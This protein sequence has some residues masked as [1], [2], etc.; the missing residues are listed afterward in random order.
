MIRHALLVAALALL[1]GLTATA[2]ANDFQYGP[3]GGPST[4][5]YYHWHQGHWHTYPSYY[6]PDWNG[7]PRLQ[8]GLRQWHPGQWH[9]H[10]GYS[11]WGYG[12]WGSGYYGRPGYY[13]GRPVWGY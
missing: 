7:V 9:Y 10:S 2:K 4:S 3:V 11:P 12:N 13:Y 1:P 6:Y 5:G 8:P